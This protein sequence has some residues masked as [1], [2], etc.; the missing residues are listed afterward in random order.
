MF[1]PSSSIIIQIN[2]IV[3]HVGR[4]EDGSLV[5][6]MIPILSVLLLLMSEVFQQEKGERT[7]EKDPKQGAWPSNSSNV[8]NKIFL[9]YFSDT[10]KETT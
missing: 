10:S 3:I 6:R 4:Y 2:I 5:T 1:D 8:D 7:T 9:A